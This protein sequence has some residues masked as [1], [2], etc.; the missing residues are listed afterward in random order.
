[1]AASRRLAVWVAALLAESLMEGRTW[2]ELHVS[3]QARA[4]GACVGSLPRE[5]PTHPPPSPSQKHQVIGDPLLKHLL[6]PHRVMKHPVMKHPVMKHLLMKHRAM[7]HRVTD[8]P[9]MQH[10][11]VKDPLPEDPLS[12]SLWASLP[13]LPLPRLPVGH[14]H[15]RPSAG[16]ESPPAPL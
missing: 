9:L 13:S 5:L 2:K 12:A 11:L 1:M 10:P 6:V 15:L 7:K 4:G 16:R 14:D 8:D 3:A